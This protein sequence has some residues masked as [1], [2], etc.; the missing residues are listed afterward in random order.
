MES[1]FQTSVRRKEAYNFKSIARIVFG[2]VW[3]I[4]G[5]FKIQPEFAKNLPSL[6]RQGSDSQPKWMSG[7]FSFWVDITKS[8]PQLWGLLIAIAELSLAFSLIFG[9]I[10]YL[11]GILTSL[12]IW[13]VPEVFGKS[14]GPTSTDIGTGIIYAIVFLLL[15]DINA[16]EGLS[17]LSLNHYIEQKHHWWRMLAEFS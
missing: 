6:I 16:M 7:W 14:Y 2:L 4:D 12:V 1:D 10:G 11:F 13:A 8:D 17:I 5:F 15:I 9:K 3:L